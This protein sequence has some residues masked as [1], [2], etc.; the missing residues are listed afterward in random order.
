MWPQARQRLAFEDALSEMRRN[1]LVDRDD[2]PLPTLLSL[3]AP[4]FGQL[5]CSG[6]TAIRVVSVSSFAA[7][8]NAFSARF[9]A[10]APGF[11]A[12]GN[13]GGSLE[14]FRFSLFFPR[15]RRSS[16]ANFSVSSASLASCCFA[17]CFQPQS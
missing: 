12:G 5:H 15:M 11:G 9:C 16:A 4:H 10:A 2:L 13:G 8:T 7:R 14:L 17:Y 1:R 6:G 3:V